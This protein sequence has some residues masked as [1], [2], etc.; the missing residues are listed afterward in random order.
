MSLLDR[1]GPEAA[2]RLMESTMQGLTELFSHNHRSVSV[3]LRSTT[4]A[5]PTAS[6]SPP[7]RCGCAGG[8]GAGGG[9][10]APWSENSGGAAV[11]Q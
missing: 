6:L 2:L 7:R 10:A 11:G 5:A 3:I 1:G 8:S 9:P 4:T